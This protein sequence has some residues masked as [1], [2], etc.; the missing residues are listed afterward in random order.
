MQFSLWASVGH[1][2]RGPLHQPLFESESFYCLKLSTQV[3]VVVVVVVVIIIVVVI[4]AA[5]AVIS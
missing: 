5:A 4:V 3:V 2:S 1:M